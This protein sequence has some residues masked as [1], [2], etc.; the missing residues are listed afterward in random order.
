MVRRDVKAMCENLIITKIDKFL[1]LIDIAIIPSLVTNSVT[2]WTFFVTIWISAEIMTIYIIVWFDFHG[3][4][5]I[6]I[7]CLTF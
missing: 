2:P 1:A 4:R 7:P 3:M 5:I 6:F